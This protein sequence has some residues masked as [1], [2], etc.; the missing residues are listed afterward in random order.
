M[1]PKKQIVIDELV[2]RADIAL[3]LFLKHK[4]APLFL[5]KNPDIF[6]EFSKK[7]A[8]YIKLH[9]DSSDQKAILD[10]ME[11]RISDVCKTISSTQQIV[12]KK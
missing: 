12:Y 1:N 9:F 3:T 11:K 4:D 8:Q 7:T 2:K 10:S 5:E 6:T